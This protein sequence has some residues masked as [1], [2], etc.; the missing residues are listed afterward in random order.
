MSDTPKLQLDRHKIN[1]WKEDGSYLKSV[2]ILPQPFIASSKYPSTLADAIAIQ[3][4]I[5]K[6]IVTKTAWLG[7]VLTD[8]IAMDAIRR[9]SAIVPLEGGD[10]GIDIDN[11]LNVRDYLQIGQL[12]ISTSY[13]SISTMPE[14]WKP[15][16]IASL[17]GM[18]FEGKRIEIALLHMQELRQ[19]E[20]TRMANEDPIDTPLALAATGK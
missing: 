12:F 1:Y 7:S 6:Y 17:N 4:E 18:N 5:I 8:P 9:M 15:S 16:A 3:E 19:R 2:Y 14:E 20:Q 13:E 10:V 11:L